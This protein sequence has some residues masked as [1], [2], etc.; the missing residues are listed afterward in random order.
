[1]HSMDDTALE[2]TRLFEVR[3]FALADQHLE[4]GERILK[5]TKTNRPIAADPSTLDRAN[6]V[7]SAFYAW[8]APTATGSTV[9][10]LGK[11]ML[12]GVEPCTDDAVRLPCT[13]LEVES[14]FAALYLTGHAEADIAHGIL[15]QLALEGYAVAPGAPTPPIDTRVIACQAQRHDQ[16]VK[17]VADPD[18][19]VKRAILDSL[20]TC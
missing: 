6:D 4:N 2:V 19:K 20:P 18:P 11:P 7:G 5:Y 17:A 12:R 8:V 1:M 10:L 15:S 16:L 13:H 9:S 14:N 3:G